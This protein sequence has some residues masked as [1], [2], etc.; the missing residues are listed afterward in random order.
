MNQLTDEE[1]LKPCD[2]EKEIYKRYGIDL[3]ELQRRPVVVGNRKREI[4]LYVSA[5]VAG[6][7]TGWGL[8]QI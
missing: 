2:R 4:F 6:M 5:G 7:F 1:L 3:E 8:A